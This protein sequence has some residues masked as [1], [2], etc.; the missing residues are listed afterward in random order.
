MNG[1]EFTLLTEILPKNFDCR[2]S[3][4]LLLLGHVQIVDENY[5]LLA[6]VGPKV[7][8]PSLLQFTVNH[9][10][11]LVGTSLSRECNGN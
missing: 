11:S 1:M 2:L 8:L 10:L 3:P 6:D 5:A 9:V 4:I 7:R